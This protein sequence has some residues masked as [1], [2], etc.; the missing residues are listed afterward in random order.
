TIQAEAADGSDFNYI[1]LR[2]L[3]VAPVRDFFLPV[4]KAV[5]IK[6]D[7]PGECSMSS[8]YL[9]ANVTGGYGSDI[10]SMRV[11]QGNGNL[12]ITSVLTDTGM[13]VTTAVFSSSCCSRDLELVAVDAVGNVATCF[14]SLKATAAPRVLTYG[15]EFFLILPV[16]LWLNMGVSLHQFMQL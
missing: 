12:T 14:K 16:C 3:V 2:L 9:T 8:W 6:A 1:V 15:A 13:V 11:L 5:N 10:P 7:C 4:C